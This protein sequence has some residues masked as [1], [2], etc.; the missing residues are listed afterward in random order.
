M[1][2]QQK[3]RKIEEKSLDEIK[4]K[5]SEHGK[6]TNED[7]DFFSEKYDALKALYKI[8]ELPNTLPKVKPLDNLR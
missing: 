5:R 8:K 4:F 7:L 6:L 2:N 3:K 1:S